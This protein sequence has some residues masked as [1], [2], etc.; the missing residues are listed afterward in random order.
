MT[1]KLHARLG[2]A[3]WWV[4]HDTADKCVSD[5]LKWQT[6]FPIFHYFLPFFKP[7]LQLARICACASSFIFVFLW[8]SIFQI[9]IFQLHCQLLYPGN[10][11]SLY[12]QKNFGP[13]LAHQRDH[14][15]CH[16]TLSLYFIAIYLYYNCWVEHK[17]LNIFPWAWF[18]LQRVFWVTRTTINC[19]QVSCKICCPFS[20]PHY[21]PSITFKT[22]SL[23]SANSQLRPGDNGVITHVNFK[24]ILRYSTQC[25]EV[26][27]HF[28][29][30]HFARSVRGKEFFEC[31]R[32]FLLFWR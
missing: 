28:A 5:L 22:F 9:C 8:R 31:A 25:D 21:R 3:P 20:S 16:F 32:N 7:C 14:L 15:K 13:L 6:F 2:A 12:Q 17:P 29:P 11:Q 10:S 19:A 26:W 1:A 24:W 18:S 23:W 4:P 30:F 27:R